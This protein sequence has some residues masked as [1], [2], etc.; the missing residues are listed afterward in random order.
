MNFVSFLFTFGFVWFSVSFSNFIYRYGS[1]AIAG[2]AIRHLTRIGVIETDN[3]DGGKVKHR[4]N[5]KQQQPRNEDAPLLLSKRAQD[6]TYFPEGI[7]DHHHATQFITLSPPFESSSDDNETAQ[8]AIDPVTPT[9]FSPLHHNSSKKSSSN[10]R[11]HDAHSSLLGSNTR[12]SNKN[13]D[14]GIGKK[15]PG[16]LSLGIRRVIAGPRSRRNSTPT[17]PKRGHGR[18]SSSNNS[19]GI[20]S[21]REDIQVLV[22]SSDDPDTNA[23]TEP[24]FR[25]Q[26]QQQQPHYYSDTITTCGPVGCFSK[27]N[28]LR[29]PA[30]E[31]TRKTDIGPEPTPHASM[32]TLS[33]EEEKRWLAYS[34]KPIDEEQSLAKS[35]VVSMSA[36]LL[37]PTL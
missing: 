4:K 10:S 23:T 36:P 6:R 9:G 20:D 18:N 16:L 33:E 7:L 34:M 28:C 22:A 2:S 19:N 11:G 35:S 32:A 25:R 29:N 1:I 21:N 5:R 15:S 14:I 37:S 12:N 13:N 27:L 3:T 24:I 17:L 31:T 26:Q 30:R 8:N